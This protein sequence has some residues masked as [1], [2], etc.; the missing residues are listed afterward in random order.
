MVE[1]IQWQQVYE[2]SCNYTYDYSRY[3]C[4]YCFELFEFEFIYFKGVGPFV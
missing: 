1:K 4:A 2:Y 3:G